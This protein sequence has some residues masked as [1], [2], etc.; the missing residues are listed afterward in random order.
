MQKAENATIKEVRGV[1]A[2]GSN[3]DFTVAKY[4]LLPNA[5]PGIA[6]KLTRNQNFASSETLMLVQ[7]LMT[8]LLRLKTLLQRLRR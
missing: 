1:V 5:A 2:L 8:R 4:V 7:R 3:D 6:G